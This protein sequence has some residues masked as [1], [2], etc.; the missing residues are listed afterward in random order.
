MAVSIF[1]PRCQQ[2]L[3]WQKRSKQNINSKPK[4]NCSPNLTPALKIT[5]TPTITLTLTLTQT[6]TLNLT[7]KHKLLKVLKKV[8]KKK[9]EVAKV[10]VE[11][12]SIDILDVKHN[13]YAMC[14]TLIA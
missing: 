1:P 10:R 3:A 2:Q 14:S 8:E 9:R 7:P 13:G 6:L 4:P 5:L 12:K 11:L